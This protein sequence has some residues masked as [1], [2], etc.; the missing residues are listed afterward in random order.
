MTTPTQAVIFCGGRGERLRPL[1]DHVPKPMAPVLNR[2]FLEYLIEQL[3]DAGVR[4]FV[5][6][7]G[8]L[9][10][11]IS[12]HFGDGERWG[13]R[14]NYH[15][16][17][18]EWET[19]RRLAEAGALLQPQFLLLYA[20][21]FAPVS[22]PWLA[23]F[24]ANAEQPLTVTLVAKSSGNIRRSPSGLIDCY[25]SS[26]SEQGLDYVE[27]GYMIAERDAILAC[28]PEHGSFSLVL[29]RLASEG[30]LAG[31]C[32]NCF[33][34]SISDL[35]RLRLTEEYLRPRKL[36]IVDRDGVI[37]RKAPRGE[38]VWKRHDFVW[39][40]EN[41]AALE[42]LSRHGFEFVV[43]SN[44]AGIG[45]GMMTVE[46]VEVLH[47][48]MVAQ[49]KERGILI[50]EV[51]ICPHSW[52]NPCNCRKPLPGMFFAAAK[53]HN[54]RLDRTLYLGDDKRDVLA[55]WHAGSQCV[56]VDNEADDSSQDSIVPWL[57]CQDLGE[58]IPAILGAFQTWSSFATDGKA[59]V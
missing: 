33:Y 10:E 42:E 32:P 8:Y 13:I 12:Q 7:T 16:G 11:T 19:G 30:R 40:E 58:A 47:E 37:N 18:A 57:R 25:D 49:L 27:I 17:P 1:T 23:E 4:E 5:L 38:Y 50:R 34:H 9:G 22:I 48:W 3:R 21:N 54:L 46:A 43:V 53:K 29:Q 59:L 45:R 44:Q 35:D 36:L 15:H 20:D 55:A 52:D 24:H 2:P 56:L 6:L 28:Q 31:F 41:I 51:F 26:R 14:I 39:L